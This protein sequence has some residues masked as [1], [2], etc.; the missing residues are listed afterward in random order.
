VREE[1][2]PT[3]EKKRGNSEN[4]R[5]AINSS[6]NDE[7]KKEVIGPAM[8]GRGGKGENVKA[9]L[10]STPSWTNRLE[11]KEI[12]VHNNEAEGRP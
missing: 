8:G 11:V 1:G 5:R 3:H 7:S 6:Y 2:T 4:A 12:R 9:G 10:D